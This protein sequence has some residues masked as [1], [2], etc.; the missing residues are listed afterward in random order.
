[1]QLNVP[2]VQIDYDDVT[3]VLYIT[4]GNPRKCF[5]HDNNNVILRYDQDCPS[6]DCRLNGITIVDA[7]KKITGFP[8]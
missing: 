2:D 7:S 4:F 1:M 6:P 8:E 3:D 5:S